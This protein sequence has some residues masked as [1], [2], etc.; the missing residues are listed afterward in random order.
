MPLPGFL[1][2]GDRKGRPYACKRASPQAIFVG[3]G[4]APA[5]FRW[6]RDRAESDSIIQCLDIPHEQAAGTAISLR[7]APDDERGRA[8]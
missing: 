2:R 6:P 7:H 1:P 3:A 5:R 4:L 8:V